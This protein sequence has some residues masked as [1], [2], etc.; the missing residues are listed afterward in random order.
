MSIPEGIKPYYREVSNGNIQSSPLAQQLYLALDKPAE[1]K[2]IVYL[3]KEAINMRPNRA[4]RGQ[5]I[6]GQVGKPLLSGVNGLYDVLQDLLIDWH[7]AGWKWTKS[8]LEQ[9]EYGNC[10]AELEIEGA[11]GLGSSTYECTI[12]GCIFITSTISLGNGVRKCS[13]LPA[14][15]HG[16][17]SHNR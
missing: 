5:A 10:Q 2:V 11:Y 6:L 3:S 17:H 16:R 4:V 1:V 9:N 14:G 13:R 7:G 12:I 8:R 15:V